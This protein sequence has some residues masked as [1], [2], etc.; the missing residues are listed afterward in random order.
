MLKTCGAL[1]A[2]FALLAAP[3]AALAKP[4]V[5]TI[6]Q[7]GATI[8]LFGS[9]H[10]LQPDLDWEPKA[11][12]DALAKADDLWFEIPLDDAG[13]AEASDAAIRQGL[14][15]PGQ[16]LSDLLEPKDRE[17]LAKLA[18]KLGL[19]MATL[20]QFKPWLAD[21]TLSDT[22]MTKLGGDPKLGVEQTLQTAEPPSVPRRAFETAAGQI[23]MIAGASQAAQLASL[24]DTLKTAE[25]DPDQFA[26]LIRLWM[27]GDAKGLDKDAVEDLRRISPEL[28]DIMIKRRNTAWVDQILDRLKGK[29]EAV[30]VVGVGHLV[31]PDS[32]PA[33]LRARGVKVDGP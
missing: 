4:P 12:A 5:W 23:G 26:R 6:H 21:T 25:D 14:M 11:L 29:G 2:A 30:M 22:F 18:A 9:V 27:A 31:G 17:R 19:P 13:Q 28:Y 20:D 3:A 7:G 33:M 1:A 16:K 8:V 32:V 10:I 15:P 24:K